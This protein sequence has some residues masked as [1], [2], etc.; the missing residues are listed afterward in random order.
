MSH[1]TVSSVTS[2]YRGR[3]APTPS[4]PLHFGSVIAALG[5][6]LQARSH[7]GLWLLRLEDLDRPRVRPGASDAILRDLERLG[8]H[9]DGEPEYQSR[10]GERYHQALGT[11][12]QAG[13]TYF[14]GC[15]RRE[16]KGLYSGTCR[17]GLPGGREPRSIRLRVPDK[18]I[19]FYDRL[20]GQQVFNL[21]AC[22]GDFILQRADHIIAYH[23]AVVVDDAESHMTEI[24]RGADLLEATAPQILLQQYLNYP[25]PAYLHLPVVYDRHGRKFSKQ[26]HADPVAA[27]PAGQ[28][29]CKALK[30]LGQQPVR[31][32]EKAAVADILDWAIAHW[33]VDAIPRHKA[34]LMQ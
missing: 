28:V 9:W 17:E 21:Q 33:N 7:N 16:V 24:V 34:P 10:H 20:Q 5:S 14:C 15:S 23:L 6:Y 22:T 26:N 1:A 19:V 2:P 31:D 25:A 3:F 27:E 18:N 11:L 32:L 30:F 13:H 8:L 29:L 4:G 12:E